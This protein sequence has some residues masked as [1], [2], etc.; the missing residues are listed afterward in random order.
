MA[1][2]RAKTRRWI[3]DMRRSATGCEPRQNPY[4]IVQREALLCLIGIFP[5]TADGRLSELDY[6]RQLSYLLTRAGWAT[7]A[8]LFVL[9]TCL[10]PEK[11]IPVFRTTGA[12]RRQC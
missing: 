8:F 5:S 10:V 2:K 1:S 6:P 4:C 3:T 9:L 7:L 12:V 11:R